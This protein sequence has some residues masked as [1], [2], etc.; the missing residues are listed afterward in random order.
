MQRYFVSFLLVAILSLIVVSSV[1]TSRA[2]VRRS[3][4]SLLCL[5]QNSVMMR[6]YYMLNHLLKS[7]EIPTEDV[8][9]LC[10]DF[11]I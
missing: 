11:S 4:H 7:D 3:D 9:K 1:G 10:D 2:K 8:G 6:N 5:G